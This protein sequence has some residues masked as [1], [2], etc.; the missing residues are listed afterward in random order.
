MAIRRFACVATFVVY[1]SM[2]GK[3]SRVLP[4]TDV[5]SGHGVEHKMLGHGVEHKMLDTTRTLSF[6]SS[7]GRLDVIEGGG[8]V[9]ATGFNPG[10]ALF[11]SAVTQ[12]VHFWRFE[13]CSVRAAAHIAVGVAD[14]ETPLTTSGGGKAHGF[15]LASATLVKSKNTH[16]ILPGSRTSLPKARRFL[17]LLEDGQ[18]CGSR[19]SL[20]LQADMDNGTIHFAIDGFAVGSLSLSFNSV[21][22]W[23]WLSYGG[24][25]V[26]IL[27]HW[28]GAHST[29]VP[30]RSV[31]DEQTHRRPPSPTEHPSSTG[32]SRPLA[33]QTPIYD[34]DDAAADDVNHGSV[35]GAMGGW[36]VQQIDTS[37]DERD[38]TDE[39]DLS[40]ES[41][42]AMYDRLSQELFTPRRSS[43]PH[44]RLPVPTTGGRVLH[45]AAA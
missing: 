9:E 41:P 40:P 35:W 34:F 43:H 38:S 17:G 33:V 18:K 5:A 32:E 29:S 20:L 37:D 22:P 28:Q 30:R 21:R 4:Y 23:V 6:E 14:A 36:S 10:G 15:H 13:V 24:D 12:G 27:E 42:D 39:A 1:Q 3:A 11:G 25:R 8:T 2:R 44:W 31:S 26:S 16:S 19:H 45:G 7:V